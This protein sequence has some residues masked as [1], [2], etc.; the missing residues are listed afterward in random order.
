MIE[1]E[2]ILEIAFKGIDTDNNGNLFIISNKYINLKK[3]INK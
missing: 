1:H 2:K 3:K